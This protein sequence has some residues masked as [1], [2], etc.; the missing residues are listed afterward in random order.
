MARL[1]RGAEVVLIQPLNRG[2]R[3]KYGPIRLKRGSVGRVERKHDRLLRSRSYDV[4]FVRRGRVRTARGVPA[5]FLRR[6]HSAS[7]AIV[8]LVVL[9]AIVYLCFKA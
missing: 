3:H 7:N 1:K 9:G 5:S 4:Q 6:R 8:L 2:R